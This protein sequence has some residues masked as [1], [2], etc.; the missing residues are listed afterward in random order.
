MY[1]HARAHGDRKGTKDKEEKKMRDRREH[2]YVLLL[3]RR[4]KHVIAD[5]KKRRR[6]KERIEQRRRK[7][8]R[9]KEKDRQIEREREREK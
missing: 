1:T 6:N 9:E 5:E 8:K 7:R 4:M 2:T 3:P